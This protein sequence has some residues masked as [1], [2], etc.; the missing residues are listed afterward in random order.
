MKTYDDWFDALRCCDVALY[1]VPMEFR[2]YQMCS[3]AV[4]R[5][6]FAAYSIPKDLV[7]REFL[8]IMASSNENI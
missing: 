1:M 7:G 5:S 3:L 4:R 8:E 6:R 2:D